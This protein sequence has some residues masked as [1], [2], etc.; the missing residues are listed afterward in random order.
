VHDFRDPV[1]QDQTAQ[2][3]PQDQLADIVR[4]AHD[5]LPFRYIAKGVK[6]GQ[7]NFS[8]V[9]QDVRRIEKLY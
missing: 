1:K 9:R 4:I 5:N 6:Q 7:C 2:H 3:E 8:V